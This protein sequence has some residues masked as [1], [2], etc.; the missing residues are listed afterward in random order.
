MRARSRL[1]V[2]LVLIAALV[3]VASG[4][5][6]A[7]DARVPRTGATA[8]AQA[9]ARVAPPARAP[10]PAA[11]TGVLLGLAAAVVLAAFGDVRI[12]HPG[13]R[14]AGDDGD[15]W[16]ATLHGAPPASA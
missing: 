15:D 4:A 16:R 13:R 6:L 5:G 2:V 11:V 1:L 8:A 7:D 9:T 12:V 10:L 14:R 3:A